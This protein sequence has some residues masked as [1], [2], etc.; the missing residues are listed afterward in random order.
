MTGEE[1]KGRR[2]RKVKRKV[3]WILTNLA[4]CADIMSEYCM[5]AWK[6]PET[7]REA[8]K[9]TWNDVW[10]V[11]FYARR[12]LLRERITAADTRYI[13]S[14]RMLDDGRE[15]SRAGL[16]LIATLVYFLAFLRLYYTDVAIVC[17]INRNMF[18]HLMKCLRQTRADD[19][20][21]NRMKQQISALR[22]VSLN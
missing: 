11:K 5:R 18:V 17:Y 3:E 15:S 9:T 20:R 10:H 6:E 22:R 12:A 2:G 16:L 14:S 7:Q 19:C 13:H 21:A 8:I 1:N 4:V